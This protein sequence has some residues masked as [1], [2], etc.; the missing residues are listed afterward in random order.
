MSVRLHLPVA[1]NQQRPLCWK[2]LGSGA[3]LECRR[4]ARRRLA[5]DRERRRN[6]QRQLVCCPLHTVTR[7][8]DIDRIH[9]NAQS[10]AAGDREG[11]L[12]GVRGVGKGNLLGDIVNPVSQMHHD[13][14]CIEM[15]SVESHKVSRI[16]AASCQWSNYRQ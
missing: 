13:P 15:P 11:E 14:C 12:F 16:R 8:H 6:H 9:S 10:R 2:H 3:Y 5:V 1:D 4:S 7:Q